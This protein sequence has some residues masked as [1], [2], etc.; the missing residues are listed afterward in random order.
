MRDR[1]KPRLLFFVEGF[2]D[3]RFVV[4]LSEISRLSLCVPAAAYAESG[5][6]ARV[7]ASGIRK[8]ARANTTVRPS[9]STS[10][11]SVGFLLSLIFIASQPRGSASPALPEEMGTTPGAP[12]AEAGATGAS[13][14]SHE[15]TMIAIGMRMSEAVVQMTAKGFGCVGIV[16]PA[17]ALVGII[18]DGDLRRHMR[19]DLLDARVE[20]I[21]TRKPITARPDQLATEAIEMLNSAKITAL[22]V[23][24]GAKPV[25]IVHMHDLL[26]AGVG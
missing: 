12:C 14:T 5:L 20:D 21:M 17:G 13:R 22:F 25:G 26:R 24:D 9:W 3:I 23:V 8:R 16:D 15:R 4:G 11:Y 7:A 6:K 2:T 19:T 18:T 1:P 10:L